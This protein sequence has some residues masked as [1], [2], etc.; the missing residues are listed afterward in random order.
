MPG[1]KKL[2]YTKVDSWIRFVS[3]RNIQA[4]LKEV[5]DIKYLIKGIKNY[6][7]KKLRNLFDSKDE[8]NNH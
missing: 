3:L 6:V 8:K 4:T 2:I 1:M 7:L 5:V